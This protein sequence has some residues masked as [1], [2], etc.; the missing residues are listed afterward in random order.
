MNAKAVSW[1]DFCRRLRREGFSNGPERTADV[2]RAVPL[3]ADPEKL[4]FCLRSILC[5]DREEWIRFEGSAV[6]ADVVEGE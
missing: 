4:Y 6:T 2:L 1:V 3:A 5:S